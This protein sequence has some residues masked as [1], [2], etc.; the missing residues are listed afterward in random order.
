[1]W[2]VQI[3]DESTTALKLLL[4]ARNYFAIGKLQHRREHRVF[5]FVSCPLH[6]ATLTQFPQLILPV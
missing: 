6:K 4:C 2:F 1:M 3:L 5:S